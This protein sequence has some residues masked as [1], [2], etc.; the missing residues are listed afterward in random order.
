MKL[1]P[2]LN[3]A[4]FAFALTLAL[5]ARAEDAS[6]DQLIKK[7]PPP[8]KVVRTDP[9]SVDPLAKQIMAA[10]K[11][12]N[13]GNAYA[14]S[15]KLAARHPKSAGAHSLHGELALLMRRYAEASAAF[16]KA[17]S[18]EPDLAFCYVGLALSEAS[19]DHISAALSSFRKVTRLYPNEDVGW[20]GMSA[21]AE[22]LGNKGDCLQYARR[23][24]AV[25]PSSSA[26]WLQ[27]SR[28][29]RISGNRQAA[30]NALARANEIQRKENKSKRRS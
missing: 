2:L 6:V 10:I 30:A 21:C 7:L 19:Q 8:E 24:T 26:A 28:A 11:K 29:E 22:R 3:L 27:L 15:Q 23:A 13:F 12:M 9:A 20:I 5:P 18:I 17:I 1:R 14:L 25:A 16:N 4:I